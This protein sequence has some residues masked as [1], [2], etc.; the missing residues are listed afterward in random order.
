MGSKGRRCTTILSGNFTGV[1]RGCSS[2]WIMQN[3]MAV[4]CIALNYWGCCRGRSISV[5]AGPLATCLVY[6]LDGAV[7][8][9][10]WRWMFIVEGIIFGLFVSIFA[11][12]S[13]TDSIASF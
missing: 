3:K 5:I 6:R 1:V 11:F 7:G 4:Y 9:D 12:Y 10:G 2:Y 13:L 8:L